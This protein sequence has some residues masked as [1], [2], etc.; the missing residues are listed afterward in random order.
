MRQRW[1]KQEV[2]AQLF[3]TSSL[4]QKKKKKIRPHK[5]AG[6]AHTQKTPAKAAVSD[7]V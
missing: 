7:T 3:P 5:Y 2:A 4:L 1:G 6:S